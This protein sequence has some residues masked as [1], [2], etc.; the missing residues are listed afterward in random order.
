[1]RHKDNTVFFDLNAPGFVAKVRS[2]VVIVDGWYFRDYGHFR[3]HAQVLRRVFEPLDCHQEKIRALLE[4]CRGLGDVLVG[5]HVRRGDYRAWRGGQYCFSDHV[6][7]D[8]MQQIASIFSARGRKTVFLLCS[9]ERLNLA[10]FSPLVTIS[11]AGHMVEDLYALA[12][13]DYIVGPPSTYSMWGSFYGEVPLFHLTGGVERL[14]IEK[15]T[16]NYG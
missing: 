2:T 11:A 8:A 3:K 4:K 13:C 14:A 6:Y 7:R 12:G 10:A 9:D 5:V 15:F 1:V 16:V